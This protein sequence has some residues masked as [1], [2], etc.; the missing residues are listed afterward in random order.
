[1]VFCIKFINF[2]E[3]ID[4]ILADPFDINSHLLLEFTIESNKEEFIGD[5]IKFLIKKN[6]NILLFTQEGNSSFYLKDSSDNNI[7]TVELTVLDSISP[8]SQFKKLKTTNKFKRFSKIPLNKNKILYIL[9]KILREIG[10]KR[11]ILIIFDSL[12]DILL[13]FDFKIAYKFMRECISVLRQIKNLVSIF[14]INKN[15]HSSQTMSAFES[16]FDGILISDAINECK[17]KGVIKNRTTIK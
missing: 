1:M 12:S 2:I 8:E 5:Y 15:S 3:F 17:V 4:S 10:G 16:L 7:I 14:L 13:W 9:K 6:I 11:P